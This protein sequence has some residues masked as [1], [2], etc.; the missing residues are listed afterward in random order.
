MALAIIQ[1]P[2]TMPVTL[3]D[4]K[5]HCAVDGTALDVQMD[6][7]IAAVTAWLAGPS[8]WL[9]RSICDQTLEWIG[10]TCGPAVLPRPPFLSLVSVHYLDGDA[11]TEVPLADVL[12]WIGEDGLARVEAAGGWTWWQNPGRR[13]RIRYRAGYGTSLDPAS[14]VDPGLQH[15]ILVMVARLLE[16][17]EALNGS[18]ARD[19][20]G[21]WIV[22][23]PS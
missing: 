7:L 22:W 23:G 21:P 14:P 16:N 6:R 5:A 20:F 18:G 9:G 19:L 3:A 1:A 17:R 4:A 2:A 15:A 11:E 10:G 13:L 8:G 12:T